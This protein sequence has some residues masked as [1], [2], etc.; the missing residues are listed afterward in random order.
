MPEYRMS[1]QR[2]LDADGNPLA[3][4]KLYAYEAGTTTPKDTY[5]SYLLSTP[6]ANPVVADAGGLFGAV[7]Q[8]LAGRY[9]FVLKDS[10]DVTI[11]TDDFVEDAGPDILT[12]R[13]DVLTRDATGYKRLAL[14]AANQVLSSDG[15]DL[16]WATGP[17]LSGTNTWTG[18][19]VF[20]LTDD[21]ASVGP[22]VTL[23]RISTTPAANDEIG[24]FSFFGRDSGGNATNYAQIL[25]AIIDPTDASEDGVLLVRTMRAGVFTDEFRAEGGLKIGA[26]T[27]GM[28]GVGTINAT[29]YYK[30]GSILG[31]AAFWCRINAAGTVL[32]QSNVAS[33][34]KNATG[35]YTFTY[36]T[37]LASGNYAIGGT[38]FITGG[39]GI[40]AIVA[41][42]STTACTVN[43]VNPATNVGADP[44]GLSIWGF[45]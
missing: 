31:A 28:L 38:A 42:Q 43:T 24:A 19:N 15:T 11:W 41:A 40:T 30:N 1:Y 37:A 33:V 35:S 3:G 45:I 21:G 39:T 32:A 2:A 27:G 25:A 18:T 10:S 5:T 12:T 16:V 34:V 14:G 6:N 23:N 44:D 36:T 26:A 13:G 9:K 22:T 7:W 17:T 8:A 4:A 20:Q 29:N